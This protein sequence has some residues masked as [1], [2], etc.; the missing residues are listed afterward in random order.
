MTTPSASERLSAPLEPLLTR[1]AA[2]IALGA[3]SASRSAA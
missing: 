2:R 1:A 3:A